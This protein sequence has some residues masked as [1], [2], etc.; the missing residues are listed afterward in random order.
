MELKRAGITSFIV[1]ICIIS[2]YSQRIYRLPSYYIDLNTCT[3]HYQEFPDSVP[4]TPF[5]IL[6]NGDVIARYEY[7]HRNEGKLERLDYPNDMCLN[8][9]TYYDG[10]NYVF[11]LGI[12][13]KSYSNYRLNLSTRLFELLPASD[14]FEKTQSGWASTGRDVLTYVGKDSIVFALDF[15]NNNIVGFHLND[16]SKYFV[17]KKIPVYPNDPRKPYLTSIY[18]TYPVACDSIMWMGKYIVDGGQFNIEGYRRDASIDPNTFEFKFWDC[19]LLTVENDF[20]SFK[21]V[22]ASF[23]D[24]SYTQAPACTLE[25]DLDTDNSNTDLQL[26]GISVKSCNLMQPIPISDNDVSIITNG[27]RLRSVSFQ[28]SDAPDEGETLEF[29]DTS[30]FG[31]FTTG[32]RTWLVYP[33]NKFDMD[34]LSHLLKN[35][36]YI[37]GG[38]NTSYGRRSV[39]VEITL[40]TGQSYSVVTYIDIQSKSN[41]AGSDVF[42]KACVDAENPSLSL[43]AYLSPEVTTGGTFVYNGNALSNSQFSVSSETLYAFLYTV[44]DQYCSDTSSLTID[45]GFNPQLNPVPIQNQ[46]FEANLQLN[47]APEPGDAQLFWSPKLAL[48]CYGCKNPVLLYPVSTEY[49]VTALA[50]NGCY[51]QAQLPVSF[52]GHY[53]P[54]VVYRSGTWDW[55]SFFLSSAPSLTYDLEIFDLTGK[56]IFNAS[57]L[58]T[59]L[60]TDGW[61]SIQAPLGMYF[62]NVHFFDGNQPVTLSGKF[63]VL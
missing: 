18:G 60:P 10:G 51:T 20:S 31:V 11:C 12:F 41:Q 4:Q 50:P 13:E 40:T 26:G 32:Q 2:C 58:S 23:S 55:N 46:L 29:G 16:P 54:A 59:A 39:S 36:A 37:H 44:G 25:L 38:S 57:R 1:F 30:G 24:A 62:F 42:T 7:Y 43:D 17:Y 5:Q 14:F 9:P 63:L 34:A 27:G 19:K 33:N 28:L 35:V 49:T 8:C 47:A 61:Q 45:V 22:N 3:E 56:C 15:K 53:L 21:A 6:P 52:Q 48:S